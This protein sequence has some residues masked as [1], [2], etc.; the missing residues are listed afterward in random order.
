MKRMLLLTTLLLASGLLPAQLRSQT[1]PRLEGKS[2]SGAEVVLPDAARGRV[3]LLL[4]GFSKASG[5][6]CKAWAAHVWPALRNDAQ[7]DVFTV[8]EMQGIPGFIKGM[9][10]GSIRRDTPED[11]RSHFVPIFRDRT[12]WRQ[13]VGYQESAPD[14]A[15]LVL[16]D[17]QG[18]IRWRAHGPYTPALA[19]QL[20][21]Q[22]AKWR[23]A[24]ER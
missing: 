1:L 6:P 21:Q 16:L 13:L 8:A 20:Q 7:A 17:P 23:P 18:V 10:V 4:F 19:A 2:L 24:G 9:V 11:Y 15:Y 14:D 22:M 5:T 12:Q 3:T